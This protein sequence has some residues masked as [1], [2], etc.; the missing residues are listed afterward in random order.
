MIKLKPCPFC[1]CSS[2]D[3]WDMKDF[4]SGKAFKA[5]VCNDCG[6]NISEN[7]STGPSTKK[8]VIA[9]NTRPGKR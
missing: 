8:Q 4:I 2:I 1:G 7:Y 3:M 9:W 5:P 6:A